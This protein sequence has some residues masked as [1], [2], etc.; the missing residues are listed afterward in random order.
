[1]VRKLSFTGSTEVGKLLMAQCAQTLKR[2]SLELGGN[3]PF[4]VFDDADV[5][6]AVAGAIASKFRNSGQ[7]CV[8]TNRLLVQDGVY[9]E[10]SEKL[11]AAVE[12][13][14]VAPADVEGA[15]Q[16][17][18]INAN[19]VDKVNEHIE[20]AVSKGAEILS[21]GEPHSLG[22]TFFE[23]TV[24]GN[25][26]ASMR[27]AAEETFGPV[28][29]IFRF[30]TEA[31]AIAMANDTP[32]GLASYIYTRDLGRAWRASESLEYGMVGVNEG[33]L[34][35]AVAPFGGIKHSGM[36]REGSKYGIE[37]YIETKYMCLGIG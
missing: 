36:G 11:V 6:A 8:C 1:L 7:T 19:A 28:A 14:K 33:I 3:A 10:F 16:G 18:L 24:I 35:T 13:M 21:G 5:D 17:P 23:P 12:A 29:A 15:Q 2:V 34:S 27:V 37:D 22:G 32:L 20:D 31:E 26:T 9:R 25:C 30:D 4:I